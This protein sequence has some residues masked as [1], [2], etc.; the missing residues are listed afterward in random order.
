MWNIQCKNF[1]DGKLLWLILNWY[2]DEEKELLIG[3]QNMCMKMA[4][5]L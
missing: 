4:V 2:I 1:V 5:E 3:D